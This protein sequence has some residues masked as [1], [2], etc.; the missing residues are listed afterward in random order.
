VEPACCPGEIGRAVVGESGPLT[1]FQLGLAL[2]SEDAYRFCVVVDAYRV[3]DESTL[4]EIRRIVEREKPAHTA[5]GVEL[6]TP[7]LRVGLQARIG[8]DAI[9]GGDPPPWTI[10]S[11]LGLDTRLSALDGAARVGEATLGDETM[12]LT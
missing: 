6:V 2:F 5:Y 12:R 9:V 1:A 3:R 8:I 7:D 4:R 10:A 11:T